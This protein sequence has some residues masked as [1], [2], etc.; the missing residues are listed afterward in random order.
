M[1]LT[2]KDKIIY[3]C[4]TKE[5][6]NSL[7]RYLEEEGATWGGGERPTET[8]NWAPNLVYLLKDL[9]LSWEYRDDIENE[10]KN[11]QSYKVVYWKGHLEPTPEDRSSLAEFLNWEDDTV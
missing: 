7:M 9:K 2:N 8:N 5:E 1:T 6:Y 3:I 4:D 11:I 10:E